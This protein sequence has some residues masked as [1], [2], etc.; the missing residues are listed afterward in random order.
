MRKMLAM[1]VMLVVMMSFTG[2]DIKFIEKVE[3]TS[4][5]ADQKITLPKPETSSGQEVEVPDW[6]IDNSFEVE[7]IKIIPF[8]K[9][10][11]VYATGHNVVSSGPASGT[12][13][14]GKTSR[15][16]EITKLGYS[17]NGVWAYIE[18]AGEEGYMK[19]MYLSEEPIVVETTNTEA[20]MPGSVVTEPPIE[21]A[22]QGSLATTTPTEEENSSGSITQQPVIAPSDNRI[23]NIT[24]PA[25]PPSITSE[26]GMLFADTMVTYTVIRQTVNVYDTPLGGVVLATY[27][28]DSTVTC[29]GIGDSGWCRIS[30]PDG[31]TGYIETQYLMK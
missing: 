9:P 13:T 27:P 1:C 8:D 29:T 4:S 16:M 18:F 30:M 28:P 3:T 31:K 19:D 21:T 5:E 11:T 10:K 7:G 25:N 12:S 15:G 2:C 23:S 20:T 6:E 24:Y 14:L 26:Y 22:V 17:A